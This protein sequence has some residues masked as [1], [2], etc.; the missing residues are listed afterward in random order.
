MLES[1][2]RVSDR[3]VRQIMVPRPDVVWIDVN[4][5][6]DAIIREILKS[7]HS[8]FPASRGEID[9]VIGI[10]HVKGLL[11]Q[12]TVTGQFD[13]ETALAEPLFI[14][15]HMPILKLLDRFK[16]SPVHMAI[17][18][19]EHGSFEGIITPTD[20][21]IAIGGDLPEHE[22]DSDPDAVRRDDGSWLLSGRI[23]IDDAE[24]ALGITGMAEDEDFRTLAG[25]IL[26]QLGRIPTTGESFTWRNWKF[27]VVDLDGR[28]VDKVVASR[29]APEPETM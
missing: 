20:I 7:G 11:Q 24:R 4:D 29:I 27:E 13:I 16:T 5:P 18:L 28:R 9:E 2:I 23:P 26:H 21:L 17:V 3:S 8:R 25:F 1:V 14:D 10:L 15:E 12:I 22:G 19:D 6:P